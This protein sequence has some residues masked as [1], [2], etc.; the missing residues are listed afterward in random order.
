MFKRYVG[1]SPKWVIKRYRLHEVA[2]KLADNEE[3][4]WAQ[5]AIELGY[6]DQSHFI[7]DFKSI[8]GESP[9]EYVANLKS[10]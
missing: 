6:Y 3:T 10:R 9:G 2:G 7:K 4:D 8:V 5:I 1:V